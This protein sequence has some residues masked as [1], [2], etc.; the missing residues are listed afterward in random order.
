MIKNHIRGEKNLDNGCFR[1]SLPLVFY[2][3]TRTLSPR[4]F[5]CR[6]SHFFYC[7]CLLGQ[8]GHKAITTCLFGEL[9]SVE[10]FWGI[11]KTNK[12]KTIS[13]SMFHRKKGYIHHLKFT[14][15]LI[16][17][18]GRAELNYCSISL[19]QEHSACRL[20]D[21]LILAQCHQ[22]HHITDLQVLSR[23]SRKSFRL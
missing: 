22:L 20:V 4:L 16:N 10:K 15:S 1:M 18:S 13:K 6:F 3:V 8:R 11:K 2:T 5:I 7:C 21:C 14:T 12:Q 23:F 19:C 17:F 9:I